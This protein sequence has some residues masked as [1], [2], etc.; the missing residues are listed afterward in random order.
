ME[1][2]MVKEIL[3]RIW[4]WSW[5]SEEKGYSFNGTVVFDGQHRVL[6]DP[7]RF[8][9]ERDRAFVKNLGPYK[10]IYLTNKDHERIACDLRREWN[11]PIWIHD[12]DV[13]FLKEKCDFSF[14]EGQE[15]SCGLKVIHLQNQKSPGESA[16]YLDSRKLLILGDALIGDPPGEL[17]LLPGKMYEDADKARSSL[18]PLRTLPLDSLIVGDGS[19]VLKEPKAALSKFFESP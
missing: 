7:V 3:P 10:A 16:F 5:F 4:S 2:R 18:G 14:V 6:I 19:H 8:D 15:L 11:V 13:P 17:R 12:L 9:H 1:A